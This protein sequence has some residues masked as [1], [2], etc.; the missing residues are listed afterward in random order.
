MKEAPGRGILYKKHRHIRIEC[1]LDA[2][3]VGSKEDRRSTSGY[4]VF[5]GGNLISW[6]SKKRNVVSRSSAELEY[7]AMTQFVCDIMWI[8]QLLMKVG[9]GTLVL[10]RLWCDNQA[11]MHMAFNPVFHERTKH[12]EINCH[13]VLEKIQ[14]GLISTR[15]LETRERLRRYFHKTFE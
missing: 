12:I 7:R 10:V 6:K 9:I 13:F 5:I 14:L 2:N 8:R 4:Y 3:W 11:T 1:F 15:Y